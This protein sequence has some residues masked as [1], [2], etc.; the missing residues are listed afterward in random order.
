MKP[1]SRQ[2][3]LLAVLIAGLAL[4]LT[5]LFRWVYEPELALRAQLRRPAPDPAELDRLIRL[6]AAD[7]FDLTDTLQLARLLKQ[8]GR[9]DD[10]LKLFLRLETRHPTTPAIRLWYAERLHQ[11]GRWAEADAE[12]LALLDLVQRQDRADPRTAA[13]FW[14]ARDKD[15][16]VARRVAELADRLAPVPLDELYRKLAENA[17]AAG[18]AATG[19]HRQV[20]FEKS[21]DF[22]A[23][24]LERN[25]G[26]QDTRGAY[27][28]LLLQS[29][30]PD[31]SLRQYQLL[32]ETDST[33][34][35]WLVSAALAAGADRQFGQ[36]EHYIRRALAVENRPE[37]RL[38]LA[39]F[40][41]WGGKH[42]AA[43]SEMDTL[44]EQFP[45]SLPYRRERAAF[46]LNAR[47]HREYL[48][49]TARLAAANPLDFDLRL[50]RIRAMIGLESYPE[51]VQEASALM[52]LEPGH[53][54]A[55]LLRAQALLWMGDYRTAQA[56]WQ[57]LALRDPD[58]RSVRKHLAQSFLWDKRYDEALAVFRPLNPAA[59]DDPEVAQGYAEAVAGKETPAADDVA[60]IRAMRQEIVRRPDAAW[61]VPL[62]TALGRALRTIGDK[63]AAVELFRAATLR[64]E[65]NLKLRLE[66]ADL[67]Q[68]L[69]RREEADRE[70]RRITNTGT[71]DPTP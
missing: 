8:Q 58:D 34:T 20:W 65:S 56:A 66:L 59:L 7:R 41:S 62:L 30:R 64:A 13:R 29:G 28:N 47:R 45:D 52:A 35:G 49:E 42:D 9:V 43:L 63:D 55:A 57:A 25:P 22:F 15:I 3:A 27:A 16:A 1:A 14:R 40:M 70:Y 48:A 61:P 50:N 17:M 71:K 39:R 24:S 54:E 38:E 33:N 32:L 18:A 37:W 6:A 68:D 2:L 23:R 11:Y 69:G 44:L 5:L 19:A 36:A 10:E 12:Y 51:A 46:L 31:E 67:L 26:N 4:G 60:A 53:R 21:Q